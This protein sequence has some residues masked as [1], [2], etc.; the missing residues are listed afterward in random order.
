MIGPSKLLAAATLVVAIATSATAGATNQEE[1]AQQAT[2]T[3]AAA[4]NVALG[5]VPSGT[6]QRAELENARGAL[7]WTVDIA[8]PGRP[9]IHEVL[10]N[11][12]TGE[13]LLVRIVKPEAQR[14]EVTQP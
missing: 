14:K 7:V 9:D 10:V 8:I 6:V 12:R 5:K 1:L 11:A 4:E 2:I 13:V 3:R